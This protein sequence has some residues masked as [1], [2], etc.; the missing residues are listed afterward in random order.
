MSKIKFL[1][2]FATISIFFNSCISHRFVKQDYFVC[3]DRVYR[4]FDDTVQSNVYTT[5]ID[6]YKNHF[7]GISIIK[8]EGNETYRVV[9]LNE[10]GM[11]FFD[12]RIGRDTSEILQIFSALDKKAL[13]NIL[14]SDFG[15]VLMNTH[16][17]GETILLWSKADKCHAIRPEDPQLYYI[18]ASDSTHVL[19]IDRFSNF[20]KLTEY[21][22]SYDSIGQINKFTVHHRNI[23][24]SMNFEKILKH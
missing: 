3:S 15:T 6:L 21:N 11:K 17:L 9:F 4:A 23:R 19:R 5:T 13:T 20:R 10:M 8:Y 14:I 12:F 1:I 2:F 18:L 22:F 16:D 7:S 24:F